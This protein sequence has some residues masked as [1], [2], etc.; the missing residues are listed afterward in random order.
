MRRA[1]RDCGA[2]S[3]RIIDK[4]LVSDRVIIDTMVSKYCD[5]CPLIGRVR[6]LV[7]RHRHRD[8]PGDDVRLGDDGSERC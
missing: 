6:S 7:A 3:H 5:H 2:A 8:Q 4:S 1:R